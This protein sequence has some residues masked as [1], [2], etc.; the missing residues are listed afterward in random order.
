MR[1][2]SRVVL[3]LFWNAVQ[4]VDIFRGSCM[5]SS[6]FVTKCAARVN[7]KQ[8]SRLV[9]NQSRETS[10]SKPVNVSDIVS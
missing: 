9:G 5:D 2:S 6:W 8:V 7:T 10:Q 3:V 1:V 4:T